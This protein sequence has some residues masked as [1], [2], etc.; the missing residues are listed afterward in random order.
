MKDNLPTKPGTMG[1]D[2]RLH[3]DY[4]WYDRGIPA[5]IEFG[6]QAYIDTSYGFAQCFSEQKPGIVLGTATGVYDRTNFIVGPRGRV[7]V[8]GYTILNGTT[9]ICHDRIEIGDHCLLAWGSVLTDTWGDLQNVSIEMRRKILFLAAT[10]PFR[11]V[12][13]VTAPKPLILEDNSWVGFEAVILPG[14]RLGRGCIVGSKTVID[15][16]VP[17]Y[18]VVAG[19]PPRIIRYLEPD[20]TDEMRQRALQEHLR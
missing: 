19:S 13:P 14:V 6:S 9:L 18:A 2:G 11:L 15:T 12:P 4:D 5:N 1:T 20:D 3:L 7:V 17:P 10:D 8:G 16:D